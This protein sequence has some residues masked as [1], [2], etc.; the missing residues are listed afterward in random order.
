L[1]VLVSVYKKVVRR[2]IQFTTQ[3]LFP[4]L[5]NIL[6]ESVNLASQFIVWFKKKAY[7]FFGEFMRIFYEVKMKNG[8]IT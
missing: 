4:F 5:F 8:F 1:R 3:I 6:N 2:S 7:F